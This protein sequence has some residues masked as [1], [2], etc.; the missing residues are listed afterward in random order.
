MSDPR[1][2]SALVP[3]PSRWQ[4]PP[5]PWPTLLDGL[6]ARFPQV[7]RA[8]WQERCDRGRVQDP[9]GQPLPAA[10]PYRVGLEVRYF[11]EV[12]DEAP[13]AAVER[14][15]HAD[16]HLV[17]ADKPHGLPVTPSGRYL[18]E[19]LLARLVARLGNPALVPLHRLDR[20][21]AGLVLFSADPGSRA[22]YQALF[23]ERRIAKTYQALAPAL[24]GQ[25]F[26]LVRASRLVR[27]EPF[28]RMAEA[29]GEANS[30]TRIAVLD[31]PDGP[32]WRYA[33]APVTGRK[34]QLRVH[35]AALG[36]PILGDT[37][38]PQLRAEGDDAC[39]CVL[40]LLACGLSFDDPLSGQ[41]R[42]FASAQTLAWPPA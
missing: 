24:P 32:L 21:T 40:Q 34:H 4:L 14:I 5:G 37:L 35:M 6:C 15:V 31:A 28:F 25:V 9:R 27:G 7:S 19:T 13:I 41:A 26:P 42:H 38:Y 23:R 8:Q 20:A 12:A 36:A 33:L 39:A 11:R 18:R 17:V 2:P 30:L 16:A 1:P 22:A 29:D 3:A 10:L